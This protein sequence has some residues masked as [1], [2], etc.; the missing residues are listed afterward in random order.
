[1][2]TQILKMTF[3]GEYKIIKNDKDQYNPYKIYYIWHELSPQKCGLVKHKKLVQK[4]GDL[5]SCMY[6]L[7]NI[8]SNG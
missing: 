3:K 2:T 1:M 4:Y 5:A 7:T 8:V 6:H